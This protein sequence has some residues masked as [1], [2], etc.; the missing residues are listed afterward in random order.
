METTTFL[1]S[2]GMLFPES[3]SDLS[4]EPWELGRY[5]A[6]KLRTWSENSIEFVVEIPFSGCFATW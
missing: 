4:D 3:T 2:V 1:F 6:V 5:F